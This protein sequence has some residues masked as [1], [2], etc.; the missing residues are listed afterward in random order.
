[1]GI[2]E[3]N[4][5]NVVFEDGGLVDSG[6]VTA[7]KYVEERCLAACAITSEHFSTSATGDK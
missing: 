5:V 3:E 7:R 2:I 6:K 1:M 4:I